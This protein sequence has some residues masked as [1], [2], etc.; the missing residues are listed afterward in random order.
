MENPEVLEKILMYTGLAGL[1]VFGV[2]TL[3]KGIIQKTFFPVWMINR[4][5]VL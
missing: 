4:A 3:F 1:V 2:F 5:T